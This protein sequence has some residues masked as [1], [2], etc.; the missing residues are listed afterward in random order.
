MALA[1]FTFL[2]IFLLITTAGLLLFYRAGMMQRLSVALAPEP[3]GGNWLSRLKMSQAGESLKAVVQPFD[4]VLPKSPQEVSVAEKRL[5]RAGYR[6]D[7]HVRI[8]YGSKVL[9]P[10]WLCILVAATGISYYLS[11]FFSYA[12]ALALGY[13]APEFWLGH[14][15][16]NRQLKIRIG[17]P[18]LLDLMV[19]CIEAGLS[20]DQA[21]ARSAEELGRSQPEISDE[22][23][24]VLLEQRAG[25]PRLE[26]WRHL[27]ER[28][29]IDII[30]T[31][32]SAIIQADQFGT[33]IAKT[34]RTYSDTLR[35]QRRQNVEEMAAKTS[36]KL[37]FPLV[38][39]ILP[40]LFIV[41]I[42]PAVI[43][44][45]EQF[46]QLFHK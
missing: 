19:V 29:D 18:E 26:A 39:F 25:R 21:L 20:M 11:P 30:R 10:I 24:L 3:E 17:L 9:I 40:S 28:V 35:V 22:F 44:M 13:L 32:V 14:R 8:L 27:A 33:S 1:I 6:E 4:K 37:V 16:K 2:A 34:L 23:G 5:I 38:L 12:C 42:G 43:T 15:I 36:V 31:L 41:T 45:V 46:Q 7:A